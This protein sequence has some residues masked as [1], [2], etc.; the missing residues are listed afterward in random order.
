MHEAFEGMREPHFRDDFFE[1][2]QA[3]NT[4][5]PLVD[6]SMRSLHANG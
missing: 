5:Y 3:G 4:G 6:A 1:A 2:W